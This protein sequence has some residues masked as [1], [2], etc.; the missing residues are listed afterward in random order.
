MMDPGFCILTSRRFFIV[1][2]WWESVQLWSHLFKKMDHRCCIRQMHAY[3]MK[4][5]FRKSLMFF[6]NSKQW[7]L[8]GYRLQWVLKWRSPSYSL[9]ISV[10]HLELFWQWQMQVQCLKNSKYLAPVFGVEAI[11]KNSKLALN[12][13]ST[14]IDRQF[15]IISAPLCF[16]PE[17]LGG[18]YTIQLSAGCRNM[19]KGFCSALIVRG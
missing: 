7:S 2:N 18:Q 19:F 1:V 15:S 11:D 8:R 6:H 13:I 17:A 9:R 14:I 3:L 10:Q 5:W 12:W 16:H 4:L